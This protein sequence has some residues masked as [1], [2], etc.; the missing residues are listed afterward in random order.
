VRVKEPE[1][2][3]ETLNA[4]LGEPLTEADLSS[5]PDYETPELDPYEDGT[6]GKV[7]FVPDIDGADADTYDQYVGAYVELPTGDKMQTGKVISRKRG[8]DGD[9]KGVAN[10]SPI[11]DSRTYEVE[12]PDGE[13]TEYSANVIAEN[14]FAQCDM[15][16]NL[17]SALVDHKKDGHAVEI[18]D[19]FVQRG[20]NRYRRITT[21]GWQLCVKWKDGSTTLE[22]LAD[23]KESY[24]IEVAEYTV[25]RGLN[26]EPA[27]AWWVLSVLTKRNR[28]IAAVNRR[29]HKRNHKFGI[30][31][32]RDW[33]EAVVFD[34]ENGS[35]LWQDAVRKEMKN[36]RIAFKVLDDGEVVPP[37]F[38][39]INCHLIFDVNWK[40]FAA[41]QDLLQVV[42]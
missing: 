32:P 5:D 13:V 16:G 17:M 22:R 40:T 38:Q 25:A 33:D 39:E 4:A 12:F 19:G 20:S 41:R 27:F 8:A 11:L 18:A 14:M 35:T 23:L 9:V 7:P 29:Y 30:K 2:F 31:V 36:M 28:I 6:D 1:E 26:K 24:P 10:T 42:T 37:C 21:K 15:E 3:S 34:K